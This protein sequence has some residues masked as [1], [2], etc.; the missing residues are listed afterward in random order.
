MKARDSLVR[1]VAVGLAGAVLCLCPHV[2]RATEPSLNVRLIGGQGGSYPLADIENLAFG[3]ETLQ[4]VA[5]SGTDS[6][7]LEEIVRIDFDLDV[8]TGVEG[9]EGETD[10]LKILHLFQNQPNPFNPDTQIAFELPQTGL[11]ELR[12]FAVNGRLVRTLLDEPRGAGPH[13]VHWDGRDDAGQPVASGVYFY[14]LGALGV[15]ESRKMI[16]LR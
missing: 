5:L 8:W 14:T 1:Y 4:I 9:P 2:G 15:D 12:I 10:V 7:V 13:S 11:A 16:L 3:S 6:Y